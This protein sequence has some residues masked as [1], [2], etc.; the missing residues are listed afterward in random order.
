MRPQE[1]FDQLKRAYTPAADAFC[2]D[3]VR[4][5]KL[6]AERHL[7]E[8]SSTIDGIVFL[9]R[10]S[11]EL[12]SSSPFDSCIG[13][14]EY[15]MKEFHEEIRDL[16]K[17]IIDRWRRSTV[18]RIV[19][20]YHLACRPMHLTPTKHTTPSGPST[21]LVQSLLSLSS[22]IQQLGNSRDQGKQSS[23]VRT[24]LREFI[25]ALTGDGWEEGGARP[26]SDLAFLWKLTDLHGAECA[27]LRRLLEQEME[28]EIQLRSETTL[29]DLQ[30][31]ASE[32]LARMQTLLA[33]LLFSAPPLP[34]SS[35]DASDKFAALLPYGAPVVDQQF[36]S[37]VELAK[38]TSRF[39]LLLVGG[40]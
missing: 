9:I 4:K 30:R 26:L 27:E 29:I 3:L 35:S 16:H 5:L 22:S 13:C 23:I 28:G 15:V 12:S 19:D 17:R 37:A 1:L 31:T 7:H 36:Q 34:K 20:K 10:V 18:S 40:T 21:E 6:V 38:P 8:S 2:G 39:G 11:E 14:Q 25:T 32:S 24:T 33:S